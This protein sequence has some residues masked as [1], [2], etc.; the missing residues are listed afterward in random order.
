VAERKACRPTSPAIRAQARAVGAT[1]YFA[2]ESGIRSDYHTGTTWAPR[3]QTPVVEVT[4]RRFSLNMISAVSPQGEFR[5]L[6]HEGS[7]TARVCREVL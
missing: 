7:V 1:I 2:D 6:L 3:G 4:G 5:F